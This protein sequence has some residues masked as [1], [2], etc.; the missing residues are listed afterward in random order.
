M[1]EAYFQTKDLAVGYGGSTLI[2]DICLDIR[3]G[4]I[5]TL[6]GPNGAGKSTILKTMSR[7]LEAIHGSIWL[8]AESLETIRR[9]ALARRMAVMLT[10]RVR[11]ELLSC[12]DVVA[13]G[14][15]PYTG[16]LGILSPEDEEKVSTAMER[17]H[18]TEFAGRDF[19]AVSD[20]QRQRIL[21]ARALCQEPDILILDEPV[22]YLDI[23][24]KLE[25]LEL[26]R[27]MAREEKLTVIL[28][29]HE[30]DLAQKVSDKLLCVRGE[31]VFRYGPVDELMSEELIRELYDLE[32]G[33]YNILFGSAELPKP[34]GKPE[35][36]VL[37]S[38]GSGIPVYHRLQREGIPFIAGPLYTNDV[39][40]TAARQLAAEVIEEKPFRSLSRETVCRALDAV[41]RCRT[42]INAGFEE[43]PENRELSKVL[44]EA[45]GK[46]SLLSYEEFCRQSEAEKKA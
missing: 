22:S 8:E 35:I 4:E 1:A 24:H 23:R 2:R 44:E 40:Y 36:L 21:L 12:R 19:D 29:L 42:V 5:V 14:R 33:M 39:D 9:Q 3:K 6:I 34:E 16:R 28:S 37:S 31:T 10:D 17:V 27:S 46:G 18:A 45:A 13:M 25:L 7:Q 20:G 41:G 38:G 43:G 30:I 11:P 26:L 32:D 15:F